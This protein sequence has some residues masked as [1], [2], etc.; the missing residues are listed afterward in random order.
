MNHSSAQSTRPAYWL[1]VCAFVAIAGFYLWNDHRAHV[2]G[3]LP[4]LLLLACPFL[5][6]FMHRKH[7]HGSG[8][9][10]NEDAHA[11]HEAQR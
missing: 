4:Y 9:P 2:W 6:F 5:H 3:A 10:P 8:A 7:E 11:G 1:L